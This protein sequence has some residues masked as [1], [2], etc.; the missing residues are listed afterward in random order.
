MAA[1]CLTMARGVVA[2]PPAPPAGPKAPSS[3]APPAAPPAAAPGVMTP[4][5]MEALPSDDLRAG[6]E[7]FKKKRYD[8]SAA[9]LEMAYM[10]KPQAGTLRLLAEAYRAQHRFAD[11]YEAYERL[12][13]THRD[14][15]APKDAGDVRMTLQILEFLT[16][17]IEVHVD[18]AGAEIFVDGRA[19][20]KSPLKRPVRVDPGMHRVRTVLQG[21]APVQHENIEIKEKQKVVLTVR[22]SPE[23][24]QTPVELKEAGGRLQVTGTPEGAIVVVDGKD[25][26]TLPHEGDVPTGKHR[27]EVVAPGH[28]SFVQDVNVKER[29]TI[30]R[31][32]TLSPAGTPQ[33]PTPP[34]PP[35]PPPKPYGL[36]AGVELLGALPLLSYP[37]V[38]CP[39]G[40]QCTES[41]LLGAG[42]GVHAGYNFGLLGVEL[43]AAGL[44][45]FHNQRHAI[46]G[47][48]DPTTPEFQA[49]DIARDQNYRV[50][51]SGV[52]VGAGPRITTKGDFVH[53]TA[54][55]APGVALRRFDVRRSTTGVVVDEYTTSATETA[56]GAMADAGVLL[57]SSPGLRLK[58]GV[59][60]W[61]DFQSG[62]LTSPSG[63]PRVIRFEGSGGQVDA[64]LP[65]PP[66]VLASGPHLYV[67]P[68]IGLQFGH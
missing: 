42:L 59:V 11:A 21:M 15:L 7:L 5:E 51:S 60:V 37:L 23:G 12:L 52:F 64:N 55:V 30:T 2:A 6:I 20:G 43:T 53:V 63:E 33:G 26:G 48:T 40:G 22:F 18:E 3:S 34:P 66:Y 61:A 41:V 39:D 31:E 32:V 57:G 25:V 62:D 45:T 19:A 27:V 13:A 16:G 46:P 14:R 47:G 58:L 65:T 44:G 68:V 9:R 56:F 49:G 50:Q 28:R 38:P 17:Q 10:V 4:A 36:Y 24:S 54:S 67:G 29:E 8:D 35:E 1:A